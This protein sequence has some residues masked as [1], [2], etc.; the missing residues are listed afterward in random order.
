MTQT[1]FPF[2]HTPIEAPDFIDFY[3]NVYRTGVA[4]GS[5]VS[6]GS[7]GWLI[8]IGFGKVVIGGSYIHDDADKIDGIDLGHTFG[9][10]RHYAVYQNYAYAATDP[11][12]T[13]IFAVAAAA[14]PPAQPII[15]ANSVKL[16]DI[17]IPD[18]ATDIL[19]ADV[20]ISNVPKVHG[21]T[22]VL[23]SGRIFEKLIQSNSNSKFFTEGSVLYDNTAEE[24]QLSDDL[25]LQSFVTHNKTEFDGPALVRGTETGPINLAIP[26]TLGSKDCIVYCL[27]DRS[28]PT[29]AAVIELKTLDLTATWDPNLA[30]FYDPTLGDQIFVF[31]LVQGNGAGFTD[32]AS[33]VPS[34]LGVEGAAL[35]ETPV[36]NSAFAIFKDEW[37]QGGLRIVDWDNATYPAGV[38]AA[39]DVLVPANFRKEGM[40]IHARNTDLNLIDPM[41]REGGAWKHYPLER[42][43][44][45]RVS[46]LVVTRP[47]GLP[48]KVAISA[49]SF[50]TYSGR[51]V[52]VPDAVQVD[53]AGQGATDLFAIWDSD[54]NT[55]GIVNMGGA[56]IDASSGQDSMPFAAVNFDGTN[57]TH[58][59]PVLPRSV[60]MLPNTDNETSTYSDPS[61]LTVSNSSTQWR[62]TSQFETVYHALLFMRSFDDDAVRPKVIEIQDSVSQ[63]AWVLGGTVDTIAG[64]AVVGTGTSFLTDYA[65]GDVIRANGVARYVKS[66]TDDFNLTTYDPFP[67]VAT[68]S[69]SRSQTHGPHAWVFNIGATFFSNDDMYE[70]L[71]IRGGA[72]DS[73]YPAWNWGDSLTEGGS[74]PLIQQANY[75]RLRI[76]DLALT[77]NGN[78][79][80]TR[81]G[82]V[83]NI[84][85]GAAAGNMR[86]SGLTGMHPGMIGREMEV[87]GAAN[88]ANNGWFTIADFVDATSVDVVNGAAV[89]PDGN[90]GSISWQT[91]RNHDV[92]ML[93][94]MTGGFLMEDCSINGGGDLSHVVNFGTS[95]SLGGTGSTSTP[96][97]VFDRVQMLGLFDAVQQGSVFYNE[98]ASPTGRL[99][100]HNCT[101]NGNVNQIFE[102]ETAGSG[103]STGADLRVYMDEV[104]VISDVNLCNFI[105]DKYG[106]PTATPPLD[107]DQMFTFS[108]CTVTGTITQVA[109][110]G[111][112]ASGVIHLDQC[113]LRASTMTGLGARAITNS[114]NTVGVTMPTTS[115]PSIVGANITLPATTP[116]FDHN[117]L[118]L[119]NDRL[120]MNLGDAAIEA[121]ALRWLRTKANSHW[122]GFGF[123]GSGMEV[124]P[125]DGGIVRMKPGFGITGNGDLAYRS[126]DATMDLSSKLSIA[127]ASPGLAAGPEEVVYIFW[128][129][130]IDE[131]VWTRFN[132]PPNPIT[133][134]VSTAI[135]GPLNDGDHD[136]H[137]FV[138]SL[139]T[140]R[141]IAAPGANPWGSCYV[142]YLGNNQRMVWTPEADLVTPWSTG[143][144]IGTTGNPT[145][146]I[147]PVYNQLNYFDT[148]TSYL[149][150]MRS[151]FDSAQG[152]ANG[153]I[154]VMT[155]PQPSEFSA[156]IAQFQ[157]THQYT[158]VNLLSVSN[159]W[160]PRSD[161]T[162]AVSY[163]QQ[164]NA[165]NSTVRITILAYIE[166]TGNVHGRIVPGFNGSP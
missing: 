25:I 131:L 79:D 82:A 145:P 150:Q 7:A 15:P 69:H 76:R 67:G 130:T 62:T 70:G 108:R 72:G 103:W 148:A 152:H 117:G 3:E 53:F 139:V 19:H 56:G 84:I 17:F 138:G 47:S 102:W 164:T 78:N 57:I 87:T 144:N 141:D 114:L 27:L 92:V 73:T 49:G 9:T 136:D 26:G 4:D 96:P 100:L 158:N 159:C 98:D 124:Y 113:E 58:M 68:T 166:N 55:F 161:G 42:R 104:V 116:D 44:W 66:V 11:A 146:V 157:H 106:T 137:I 149:V 142:S 115:L 29:T 34:L 63:T 51:F 120:S 94:T 46:G 31:A 12:P 71:I 10:N 45:G 41:T 111:T 1:V 43:G 86:L 85:A 140:G 75:S 13:S 40:L 160:V 37:L 122:D 129:P 20:V 80:G 21:P 54:T 112:H 8:T 48:D 39:L 154:I 105:V 16:A 143:A 135:T 77:Y 90:N 128:D 126:T 61:V 91:E 99:S 81:S 74:V 59:E 64:T 121:H 18:T 155:P 32:V 89:V 97:N 93:K 65:Q 156:A 23:D 52:V 132:A 119:T 24:I 110:V 35:V 101:I 50:I 163:F 88:G 133:G 123:V 33:G 14:T 22:N 125:E 38:E 30:D 127:G 134:G 153:D 2:L 147:V 83:A 118:V 151:S 162:S 36:G 165:G 5:E 28:V 60:Q 95:M 6:A 107:N 109:N